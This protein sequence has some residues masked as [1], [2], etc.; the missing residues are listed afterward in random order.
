MEVWGHVARQPRAPVR[1]PDD[2]EVEVAYE[3]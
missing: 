1:L 3:P 2:G